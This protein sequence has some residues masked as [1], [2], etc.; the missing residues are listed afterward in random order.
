[1]REIFCTVSGVTGGIIAGLFGGWDASLKALIIFMVID[2]FM[3][4]ACAG[5]FKKSPKTK[6]GGLQSKA[7]WNGLCKK[8]ATLGL[9]IVA[10]QLDGVMGTAYIRDAVCIG[11]MANE[12]LSMAENAGLMGVK[13]PDPIKRAID[14]LQ[15]RAAAEKGGDDHNVKG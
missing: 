6:T 15:D 5:I 13:F 9:V 7:G 11:F 1:M 4:L 12:L 2:Y 10:V 8:V 14:V 3:G